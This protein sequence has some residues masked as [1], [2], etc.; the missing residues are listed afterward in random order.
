VGNICVMFYGKI[1]ALALL[2]FA[3]IVGCMYGKSVDMDMDIM[4][5][6]ISTASLAVSSTAIQFSS[7]PM[8]PVVC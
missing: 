2:Y 6:F 3:K 4:G 8:T 1:N 5:N 7:K